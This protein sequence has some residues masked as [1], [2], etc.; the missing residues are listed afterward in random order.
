MKKFS[1][2]AQLV[3]IGPGW[4]SELQCGGGL[5]T[6]NA[7]KAVSKLKRLDHVSCGPAIVLSGHTRFI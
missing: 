2:W 1:R 6:I 5:T 3:R 4:E 7:F